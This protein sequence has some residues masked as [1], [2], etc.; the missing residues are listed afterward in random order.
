MKTFILSI[1]FIL[2][3]LLAYSIHL[4]AED[5]KMACAGLSIPIGLAILGYLGCRE[6]IRPTSMPVKDPRKNPRYVLRSVPPDEI[7][8]AFYNPDRFGHPRNHE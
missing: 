1:L 5:F 2:I 3:G 4:G 6:T 8:R 7:E